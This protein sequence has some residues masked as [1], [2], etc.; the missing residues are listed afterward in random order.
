M[1]T[2]I[3]TKTLLTVKTDKVLK[4]A[5]QDLAAEMGL[6]LGTLINSMLKQF[7]RNKE[8]TFN[9]SYQPTPYL[10]RVIKEAEADFAAGRVKWAD[11]VDELIQQLNS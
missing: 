9:V 5:A 7:V 4:Q 6:P 10:K 3:N 8:V 2:A 11:N 1:T